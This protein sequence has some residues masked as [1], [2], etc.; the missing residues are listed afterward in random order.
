MKKIEI[1]CNEVPIDYGKN[2][3]YSFYGGVYEVGNKYQVLRNF[4]S[5]KENKNNYTMIAIER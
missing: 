4:I 5:I 2:Y 3:Y 1:V